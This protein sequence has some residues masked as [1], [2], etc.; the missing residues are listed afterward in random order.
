M[1]LRLLFCIPLLILSSQI[2]AQ[3]DHIEMSDDNGHESHHHHHNEI[4][5]ANA[6]VY[7]VK[8]EAFSYGLH[9]HYIHTVGESKFG[10][11]AGYERIFDEHGHNTF[12]LIAS[13]RPVDPLTFILSPGITIEDENPG[14]VNF[15]LHVE[16]AYEFQLDNIHLGP[17][18]EFAYDPEDFHISLG[19]HIGYGF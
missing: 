5:I 9:L 15:A 10:F 13:Y 16:T 14:E 18:L 19:I 4:G 2:V 8:E 3:E 11:G 1:T 17:V 6:L 7:F 12:G